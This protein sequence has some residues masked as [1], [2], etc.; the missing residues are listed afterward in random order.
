MEATAA[1]PQLLDI[2][3][4]V[5]TSIAD[6]QR[7]ELLPASSISAPPMVLLLGNHS[8]GKSSLINHLLGRKVQRTGV[9]PTDDGFTVLMHG[10]DERSI[11]GAAL[12]THPDL[13]FTDLSRF[14]PGLVQH[15]N[16][17]FL[18]NEL[19]RQVRLIDSP[20]MIDASGSG[21][22]R[23][24][25]FI[26]VTRWLAEQCDLVLLFFDPEKPGTTG[27]TISTLTEALSGFDHKL[28]I[29]MNKM[30]LFDGIRDFA[31]TYGALC[32]NLS[33]S[34]QTKDMPHIYTTV[35]PELV[36]EDCLLPLDGFAAA[37][38]ELE[39]YINNLPRNRFDTVVSST[40]NECQQLYIRCRVSEH[41]RYKI[42]SSLLNGFSTAFLFLMV[43]AFYMG[44]SIYTDSDITRTH[45]IVTL[46]CTLLFFLSLWV[47]KKLAIWTERKG[48]DH[49]DHTFQ[50]ALASELA[51]RDLADDLT[52]TWANTRDG[53]AKILVTDGIKG[54]KRVNKRKI[55]KLRSL[56]ETELPN[57]RR[58]NLSCCSTST[59]QRCCSYYTAAQ[60]C[61]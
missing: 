42:R 11:D 12:T 59:P 6:A 28:R 31:R 46:S 27:E 8:S 54:I 1:L 36:R 50:A 41:L 23:Q 58:H 43:G 29:V 15:M 52:Y 18:D 49:L 9:A 21:T 40:I 25:D 7:Y 51:N 16:G 26:A 37:L 60:H 4:R 44:F 53:L 61:L 55:K 17:Q 48:I 5:L 20:G 22:E 13:P 34:L 32:W 47:T 30:D 19:L 2:R 56:I 38:L 3:E 14:G 33:R 57:L 45:L 10:D 24:Y 39:Q 35:I